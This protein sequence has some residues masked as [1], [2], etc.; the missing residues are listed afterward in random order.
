MTKIKN[1]QN[2]P[3]PGIEYSEILIPND[4]D[5]GTGNYTV[6]LQP[7]ALASKDPIFSIIINVPIFQISINFNPSTKEIPVLLGKADNTPPISY[8]IFNL[9]E[10]ILLSDSYR[11]ETNFINWEIKELLM[12]DIKLQRK[13]LPGT[14]SFWFDPKKNP[15]AFT[16]GIKYSWGIFKI[17]NEE[18]AIIS[19]GKMLSVIFNQNSDNERT[20][21]HEILDVDHNRNHMISVTWDKEELN[22]YFD[23]KCIQK[24]K[25]NGQ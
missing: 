19:D 1:R 7:N 21:F 25:F 9:P 16:E 24:V 10:N 17:N 5:L 6:I 2:N 8:N 18:C 3:A 12:N 14:V 11:F 22:L 20:I 23:G 4:K 13:I 15:N